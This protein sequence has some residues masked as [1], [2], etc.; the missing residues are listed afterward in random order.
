MKTESG[1]KN[2]TSD[3]DKN[4]IKFSDVFNLEDV[5][6]LQDLFSSAT[7][8]ASIITDPDGTPITNSSNFSHLCE[9]HYT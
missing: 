2:A 4:G 6:R 5:Q 8:V 1:N 3:S 7:G 9:K